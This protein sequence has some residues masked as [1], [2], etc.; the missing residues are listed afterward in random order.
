LPKIDVVV[1][2]L[3]DW[4]SSGDLRLPEIQRRYVW[5]AIRVRDFFDSLYRQYP[6]GTILVWDTAQD[7]ET[8]DLAVSPNTSPKHTSKRIL[9]DGQQRITSLTAVIKGKPIQVRYR[10]RPIQILF[11][12]EHPEGPPAEVIEVE[13]SA[14][15][16]S[17]DEYEIQSSNRSG[18]QEELSKLTFIV[19]GSSALKNNPLW[20]PVSDIFLKSDKEILKPLGISSDDDRWDRYSRRLQ[21]VRD[22]NKYPYVMQVLP[23][24]MSYQ[25]VTQ[26]FVRVNS[27]GMKLRGHDLAV[28]QISARW[29]GFVDVIEK[30]ADE[31]TGEDDYLIDTGIVVR[32]LVV[33][34]TNQCRFDR[35]AR[36]PLE[37]LKESFE[38]TKKGLRYAIQ[39]ILNNALV[40]TLDNISSPYLLVPIAVY[41]IL[42]DQRI[43]RDEDKLLLKWF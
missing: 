21:R 8:K 1:S 32:T 35:I 10:Q 33:F 40:G 24:E 43:S 30:F 22:I 3:V 19:A 42:Q 4:T 23:P 6:S 29:K 16:D 15:D 26:I 9:L 25:E 13:E 28:A 7:I 17:E 41:S 11:N 36:V 27:K 34:A 20:I 37:K 39:F 14:N 12:L 5:T 31:F 38:K 18:I 2:D